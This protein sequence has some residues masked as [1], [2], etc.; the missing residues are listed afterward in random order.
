M[1]K[2]LTLFLSLLLALTLLFSGC[3]FL[4]DLPVGGPSNGGNADD[5][6]TATYADLAAIPAYSKSPYV[7]LNGN[8]PTFTEEEITDLSY[9]YFSPL[10]ALGR[11][12]YVEASVGVDLMP[13]E[14]RE[15]ISSVKPSGWINKPYDF[16]DGGYLYNRCHL[17]GFQLTGENANKLN[18]ITGTRYMNVDGMLP[19]ENMVADYVRETENHVM[20]RVT[21]IYLG[22]N[23][24]AHGVQMEA[25]SVEDGGEDICFNVY[26]YNVQPR[27]TIDYATG[28]SRQNDN[29][30]YAETAINGENGSATLP[31]AEDEENAAPPVEGTEADYVLNTRSKKIHLPTCGSVDDMAE[32]NK[33]SY[34]GTK[35]SLLADGYSACG[36][37]KP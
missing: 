29:T 35:E 22:D 5:Q 4:A 36:V 34:H 13:T 27:I 11:C 6:S 16:V 33:Q 15:S 31:P 37:C 10:D 28:N 21:P 2:Q 18:L 12:G 32:H 1:K 25:F 8:V 30:D 19:F 14:D 17:L 3:D 26:V 20:L 9:E 23:L 7:I 24:V